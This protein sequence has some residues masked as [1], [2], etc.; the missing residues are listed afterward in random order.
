MP[1]QNGNGRWMIGM[2]ML[3]V[4]MPLLMAAQDCGSVWAETDTASYEAGQGGVASLHNETNRTAYLPG[5]ATFNYER[6]QA[7]AWQNAGPNVV[8]IWEGYVR[9]VRANSIVD[10]NFST[11][12]AGTYRIR[13]N[14]AYGCT[15]GQPMS[16]AGCTSSEVVYTESYQVSCSAAQQDECSEMDGVFNPDTCGCCRPGAHQVQECEMGQGGTFDMLSCSC[17]L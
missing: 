9:P 6:Y 11:G 15:E 14:V 1:R 13:Y 2:C 3:A 5:C 12:D 17:V 7:G 10:T 16:Q 8:C 4:A